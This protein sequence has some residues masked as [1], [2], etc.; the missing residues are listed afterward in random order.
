M[1]GTGQEELVSRTGHSL[2]CAAAV[3][4][5]VLPQTKLLSHLFSPFPLWD[6]DPHPMVL[7]HKTSQP[8]E[9]PSAAGSPK[10][11]LDEQLQS[12]RPHLHCDKWSLW[13]GEIP[14]HRGVNPQ[15]TSLGFYGH[16]INPPRAEQGVS[17]NNLQQPLLPPSTLLS[18][19]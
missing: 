8:L 1:M 17:V 13:R 9:L 2:E 4:T 5:P 15:L 7:S 16:G 18:F 6:Q 14:F 12:L 19:K 3:P 10:F 11:A